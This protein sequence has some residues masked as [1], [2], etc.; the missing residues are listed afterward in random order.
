M[1]SLVKVIA[2]HTELKLFIRN[3]NATTHLVRY[4]L[5]AWWKRAYFANS[6]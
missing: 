6:K 1:Q 3:V 5:P 4:S 2:R